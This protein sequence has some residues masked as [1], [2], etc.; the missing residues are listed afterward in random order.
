[1]Q[2]L[3]SWYDHHLKHHLSASANLCK[4]SGLRLSVGAF[5][6][7]VNFSTPKVER[8]KKQ[9]TKTAGFQSVEL[10]SF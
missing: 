2:E 1:V 4:K 8:M 3:P 7:Q 9:K 6:F 5:I 10:F